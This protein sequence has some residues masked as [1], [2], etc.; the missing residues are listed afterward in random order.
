MKYKKEEIKNIIFIIDE[1]RVTIAQIGRLYHSDY[2][3]A[4]LI[5]D[6]FILENDLYK[7]L[8]DSYK[9]LSAEFKG[10]DEL[11]LDDFLEEKE[12]WKIPL[13]LDKVS[14]K[15]KIKKYL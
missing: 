2:E 7:K 1:I 6:L 11:E 5:Q 14:I 13:D 10:D 15:E 9:V 3:K 8:N 12:Y 4:L